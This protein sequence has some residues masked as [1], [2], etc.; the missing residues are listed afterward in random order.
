MTWASRLKFLFG[1]IVVLAIVAAGTLVFN[2]RELRVDSES[3]TIASA[4]ISVGSEYGG[5]VTTAYVEEDAQVSAGDPLATLESQ[6]LQLELAEGL[7]DDDEPGVEKDGSYTVYATVD[8]TLSELDMHLGSFV[9]AGD[10]V[11]RIDERDTLFV[12]AQF[13]LSPAD[14]GRIEDGA[15]VEFVL[16]DRSTLT[17]VVANL[18]VET[19]DGDALVTVRVES[20]DLV[21]GDESG[22]SDPG[23]PVEATL[24]LRDDGPLAGVSDM[25]STFAHRIGL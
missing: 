11:A 3:A 18:D 10:V 20:D 19:V 15:T 8:G 12:E 16:P 14:F 7:V 25:V 4:S 9:Q 1:L 22:L 24:Y 6:Q 17:G 2:Q 13:R 21:W 23:T 5:M